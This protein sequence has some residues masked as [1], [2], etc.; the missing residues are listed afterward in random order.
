[1]E[2]AMKKTMLLLVGVLLLF[3]LLACQEITTVT[4]TTSTATEPTSTT[5]SQTT[6]SSTT[7]TTTTSTTTTTESTT[8]TTTTQLAED[9]LITLRSTKS[10]IL[11]DV[12]GD[13]DLTK[14]V[15]KG[16]FGEL[17]LAEAAFLDLPASI[18]QTGDL[19]QASLKGIFFL[20][21]QSGVNTFE[22]VLITKLVEETEYV[23]FDASYTSLP[24][25]PLP[26]G[27]TIN[28]GSASIK[29][30]RIQLEGR[31]STP[32]RVLL[33]A[34]LQGFKNYIIETDF[35]ILSANEP[36]RWASFMYRFGGSGYFQ[37]AIRQNATATNG[38]EF[39]KWINGGWNVPKTTSYSEAINPEKMYRL[40]ID[41]NGDVVNEYIDNQLM[42]TYENASDFTNGFLGMQASG[43][44]AVY[45][46]IKVTLPV[47]YFDTSGIELTTLPELY[48]PETGAQQPP[49]IMKWV[50]NTADLHA[51][52]EDIRP[53]VLIIQVD[54]TMDVVNSMGI[55]LMSVL[56]ALKIIDGRVIP[57]FYIR[58]RDVAVA[59]A[60]MLKEYGVRDVFMISRNDLAIA[61]AREVNGMLRG[62]LEIDF[63]SSNPTL[64]NADLLEIRDRVNTAGAIGAML[65]YQYVTRENIEYLQH[66][67]VSVYANATNRAAQ[68][69]Y[70]GILA[71]ANGVLTNNLETA[72]SLLAMLP[73]NSILRTP[74]IIGHRGTPAKAPENSLE[75]SVLAFNDGAD[76]IEL[77]IFLSTD[78]RLIVM[79]DSTTQ[80][81]T[82]GNLTVE[83]STLEQLKLLTL[84]DS[85]GNFPGLRIPTLD[86]YFAAFKGLDVQIF[87]EIKSTKPEIVSVLAALIDEYDFSDQATVIT[88]HTS[89]ADNMREFLPNISVGYLNTSLASA[90]N[91]TASLM[92]ILNSVVPIKTTYNPEAS[93]LTRDLLTQLNYRGITTWP[94]TVNLAADQYKFFT[95][96]VGG[97]TTNTTFQMKNDWFEVHM[98]QS[99]FVVDRASAPANL[100]IRGAIE[101]L[102]GLSYEYIPEFVLIDDGGTGIQIDALASVTN[103]QNPGTALVMV[104]FQGTFAN[105]TKYRIYDQLVTIEVK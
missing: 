63:V 81:T 65:P 15:Y 61:D 24:D 45:N 101:T 79:H 44:V 64:S 23:V 76:V 97:I 100:L 92:S 103:F 53:Q 62:I 12:G 85:T 31:T 99:A 20:T 94:W 83:S 39:A 87:I 51:M 10:F 13:I 78:N 7:T 93:P 72:Y 41:L 43:A 18:V 37:M 69:V 71:G 28:A 5:T 14:Y 88:F 42:I 77:D 105:G 6:T 67:L 47:D 55:R 95:F 60:A 9:D 58:N 3:G 80:R 21:M 66:R 104:F 98:N 16:D 36:T 84:L 91:L 4:T 2:D 86:E 38:V 32:T 56:D 30:G 102:G 11:A 35:T 25:G 70:Q 73:A 19:L 89:Q 96:G 34:Y 90:S 74:L 50:E 33:P 8:T 40:K 59:V 17:T 52:S 49:A 29:D 26:E 54:H 75:G 82:N 68:F 22:I 46:N 57:A 27:Y 48:I 1:M